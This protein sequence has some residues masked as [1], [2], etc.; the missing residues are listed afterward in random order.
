MIGNCSAAFLFSIAWL[1][2]LLL[3][4]RCAVAQEKKLILWEDG[5]AISISIHNSELRD[6]DTLDPESHLKVGLAGK[7]TT[8]LGDI[9]VNKNY[10]VFTPLWAFSPGMNYDVYWGNDLIWNFSVPA[11]DGG[12]AP[13]LTIHPQ[14]DTLPEN[15]LKFH[16]AFS[17]PMTSEKSLSYIT[18]TTAS[19]DTLRDVLLDLHPELWNS[20]NAVLTIWIDPGRIKRDLLRNQELGKPLVQGNAYLI[21]VSSNW[22]SSAGK[23]LNQTYSK[24]FWVKAPDRKKPDPHD[25][26]IKYPKSSTMEPLEIF[27]PEALDFILLQE[28]ITVGQSVKIPGEVRISS[29]QRRWTFNPE[30][31]WSAGDYTL[32]IEGRL[33]DLAGNNLNRLFDSALNEDPDQEAEKRVWEITFSLQ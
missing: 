18:T 11:I 23:A 12:I 30:S 9:L 17:Q 7:K 29:D 31:S 33:E 21:H 26:S 14:L 15:I 10:L 19:G 6:S 24:S 2:L 22:K 5:E 16:F 32:A 27:L 28:C 13:I 20:D 25:W 4:C 1:V 3:S 8:I